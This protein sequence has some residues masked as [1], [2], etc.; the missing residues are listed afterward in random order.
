MKIL[1][2]NYRFFKSGGPE[3]YLFRIMDLLMEKNHHVEIFSVDNVKNHKSKYSK[4][5]LSKI[6]N[7]KEIYFSEYNLKN[8]KTFLKVFSRMFYSFE[9]KKNIKKILKDFNPDIV[10]ILQYKNKISCSILSPIKKMKIPVVQRISDFEK[11][12]ISAN[13]Y[14]SI[15]NEVCTKCLEKET[16]CLKMKCYSNSFIFSLIKFL[17]IQFEKYYNVNSKIDKFI[18]PSSNS[19]S[20]FAKKINNNKLVHIPTFVEQKE[21]V[22]KKIEYSDFALYFGRLDK[23]KGIDILI[24][25]FKESKRNLIIIGKSTSKLDNYYLEKIKSFDNIKILEHMP[26][27]KL[28]SYLQK[29]LFTIVP[30][31]WFDNFPNS[32]LESFSCKKS[33]VASDNGS[34]KEL[35]IDGFNGYTFKTGNCNSLKNAVEKMFLNYDFTIQMGNNSYNYVSKK[36]GAEIHYSKL[37]STFNSLVDKRK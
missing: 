36:Y 5:F 37:M 8:I 6:G 11:F 35:V 7:G 4:L 30:S 1:I 34:L 16:S 21:F 25:A 29:C 26:F 2:I 31:I 12:C 20:L 28:E 15:K 33:V 19:L 13:F 32:V 9:A 24:D 27:E 10:Y 3:S 14:N 18:F 23:E 22:N 17:S